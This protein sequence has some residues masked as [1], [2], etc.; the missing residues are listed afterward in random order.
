M[1]QIKLFGLPTNSTSD[2]NFTSHTAVLAR[3]QKVPP[4]TQSQGPPRTDG[5]CRVTITLLPRIKLASSGQAPAGVTAGDL[6]GTPH[7][8]ASAGS[9]RWGSRLSLGLRRQPPIL[10][11]PSNSHL[12]HFQLR[13]QLTHLQSSRW[14]P[15]SL[16][17]G[18]LAL[19]W[20]RPS[21]LGHLGSGPV[22]G[23]PGSVSPSLSLCHSFR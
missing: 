16:G 23:R 18:F 14:Q 15:R 2:K 12:L 7:R 6:E 19:A 20:S 10:H 11:C 8:A 9:R 1:P 4:G 3:G 22:K 5:A 13:S 21:C 17:P